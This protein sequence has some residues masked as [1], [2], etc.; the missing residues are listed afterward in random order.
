[1]PA[2]MRKS[3]NIDTVGSISAPPP[4]NYFYYLNYIL[5]GDLTQ[6]VSYVLEKWI[7]INL[8]DFFCF[9]FDYISE[10]FGL[11]H[12]YTCTGSTVLTVASS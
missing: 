2:Y 4:Y 5:T 7:L 9:L 8:C 12:F 1:M 6:G 11:D 3:V 10:G